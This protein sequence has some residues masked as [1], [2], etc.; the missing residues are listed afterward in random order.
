[1]NWT[2]GLW[3]GWVVVSL[4]GIAFATW[5]LDPFTRFQRLS[6]PVRFSADKIE[7][8]FP[9]NTERQVVKKA[10]TK[11][12]QEQRAPGNKSIFDQ[13]D[14]PPEKMAD[15]IIGEYQPKT[16]LLLF[17]EWAKLSLLPPLVLL[18]VGW[19]LPWVLRGFSSHKP[20]SSPVGAVD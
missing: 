1:M 20:P 8:E 2:R 11:W 19:L 7:L 18:F 14:E 10:I 17:S 9:G 15:R 16:A 6:D 3:R 12:I 4:F 13:F 5:G